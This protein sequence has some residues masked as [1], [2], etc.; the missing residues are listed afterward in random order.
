MSSAHLVGLS[1]VEDGKIVAVKPPDPDKGVSD[2]DVAEAVAESVEIIL[3]AE[4]E[5][6]T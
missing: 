6:S 2:V 1:F 5:M 3:N 4:D